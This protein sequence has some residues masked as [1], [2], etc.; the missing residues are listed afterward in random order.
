MRTTGSWL[1]AARLQSVR[2]EM[3]SAIA[4]A[5]SSISRALSG[6]TGGSGVVTVCMAEHSIGFAASDVRPHGATSTRADQ[7]H[8]YGQKHLSAESRKE[9]GHIRLSVSRC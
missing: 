5:R 9:Y 6:G 8:R 2:G 1:A 4:A 7:S 3:P